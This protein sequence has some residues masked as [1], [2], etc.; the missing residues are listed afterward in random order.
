MPA[1]T[2]GLST[3][4]VAQS[5]TELPISVNISRVPV[6][7]AAGGSS[8]S[9]APRR[10]EAAPRLRKAYQVQ[11][12][13]RAVSTAV[14]AVH[15][16]SSTGPA[17]HIGEVEVQAGPTDRARRHNGRVSHDEPERRIPDPGFGDDDGS[18]DP[19]LAAALASYAAGSAGLADV[20]GSLQ[21]ARLLVPV[22]AVLGEVEDDDAGAGARQDQRHGG[23]P[24]ARP[25]GRRALLAFTG[26]ATHAA[27]GPRGPAGAGGG[28][29]WPPQAA[30]QEQADALVVDLAGPVSAAIEG[31]DL[32]ALAAGW[33][34]DAGWAERTG[35]IR[36][37]G[38]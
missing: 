17:W 4:L 30:L 15:V 6:R 8:V 11:A 5:A 18:A 38:E 29:S 34:A 12:A 37:P 20:L 33:R 22:V 16:T 10:P 24:G 32:Q 23:G 2:T 21:A 14:S 25:D 9:P 36:P 3:M 28:A 26:Q 13:P 31:E 27:L 7:Y 35:W 1:Q 19:A